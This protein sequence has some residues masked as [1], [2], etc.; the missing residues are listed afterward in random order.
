MNPVY[1]CKSG[2]LKRK[3]SS[4]ALESADGE[5][6]LI[7]IE[8]TESIFCFG[9]ITLNKRLLGLLNRHS[10]PLLF[11]N[12]YGD[13]IGS[14]LPVTTRTGTC[15]IAQA[16]AFQNES[17]RLMIAK[18]IQSAAF[19]NMINI[20]KYYQKKDKDLNTI[21][22]SLMR[23][24]GELTEA[25]SVEE[26]L[27]LEAKSKS[28]YYQIFDIIL[29]GS[30]FR[31]GHRSKRPP[32]TPVNSMI[33]YGNTLLYGQLLAMLHQSRL[34]PEISFIHSVVKK[35]ASL[36]YDLADIYKPFL[37][38]RLLMRL[39]RKKEVKPQH[40]DQ[41]E[42]SCYMNKDGSRIFVAAF[43]QL[44]KT[45]VNIDGRSLSYK[46]IMM[47]DI[48]RLVRFIQDPD[49]ADLRFFEVGW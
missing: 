47:R 43:Q 33:S 5:E 32:A 23:L 34:V 49:S 27:L 7:P 19:Q 41:Q 2:E 17:V 38:D 20:C 45:T 35:G 21:I 12:Y 16:N 26:I 4:L 13:C 31:F 22:S 8:Q 3:D 40:F 10:I 6:I 9:E 48:N 36:Q 46:S 14:F 37:V 18:S 39:V 30:G 1:L 24:K 42:N 11:F 44:L 15:L 29:A 28:E 25:D